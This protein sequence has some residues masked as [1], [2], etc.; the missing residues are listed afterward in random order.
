MMRI[1]A[2]GT[3][4][5]GQVR[6]GNE[7]AFWSGDSV[8][9]VADGMGGHLA[10]EVASATALEPVAAL[11][12]RIF[13]DGDEALGA[14]RRAVTQANAMVARKA[15]DEP[16]FRGMGTT[17]TA[18]MVEGRRLHLA[19]VGDSRAY[20]LRH[21]DLQQVT[22]DH[23]LVQH[24]IN[25]GQITK[26]EASTHPQRSIITRAIGV[27]NDVD[28]DGFT[29]DLE[30]GD[31]VLL[32]SDGLT[33][34]VP[35]ERI[36]ETLKRFPDLDEAA[37]TLI[38]MANEGGGPD[39][40]TV[41]L[42]RYDE[43]ATGPASRSGGDTGELAE[44]QPQDPVRVDSSGNG[45]DGDWAARL[46]RFGNLGR[47][48]GGPRDDRDEGG[49]RGRVVLASLV[50]LA[51]FLALVGAGGWWLLSRSYFV[52]LD[53]ENVVIYQGIPT[54]LGPID[55]SWVSEPTDI[56]V[57]DVSDFFVDDLESG[58]A[59]VDLEDARRIV[60]GIPLADGPRDDGDGAGDDPTAPTTEP[61]ATPT[62]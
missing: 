47:G 54:D 14:L 24:L 26:E 51:V 58:L 50:A 18:A 1:H 53:G 57:D 41:L 20:L 21:G 13:A 35:D 46:G 23:T 22:D 2:A 43:T 42:L 61:D 10:G 36:A 11:D 3:T 55:L 45:S 39:N 12:G 8:F 16:S 4:D 56:D 29:I 37:N 19:H 30:Q 49:G 6:Q 44:Q 27:A 34:V 9:A 15:H 33:G 59:A 32:C 38:D 48:G 28:V 25:E 52:G 40:I 17:L 31:V 62:P 7:D 60:D 5:T